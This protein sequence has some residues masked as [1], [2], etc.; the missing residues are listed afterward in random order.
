MSAKVPNLL[1][2]RHFSAFIFFSRAEAD[3]NQAKAFF[4]EPIRRAGAIERL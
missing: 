1:R 2:G 4:D 3:F